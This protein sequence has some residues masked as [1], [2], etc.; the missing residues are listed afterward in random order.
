ML[1]RFGMAI[2]MTHHEARPES[3]GSFAPPTRRHLPGLH[4]AGMAE[5]FRES[6][7]DP[8][9]ESL[10]GSRDAILF[11]QR[12]AGNAAVTHLLSQVTVQPAGGGAAP[13][14]AKVPRWTTHQLDVIQYLLNGLGLYDL[15]AHGSG[16]G[17][18]TEAGLEEAFAGDD[19]RVM[20]PSVIIKA[21]KT[22]TRPAKKGEHKLG[23]GR[24]FKDGVLDMT[25]AVGFHEGGWSKTEYDTIV[26]ALL[27]DPLKFRIVSATDAGTILKPTGH[28][29][30]GGAFG[31]FFAH[32]PMEYT[33]P[34]GGKRQVQIILRLVS[35]QSGGDAGKAAAAFEEGM[36]QSDVAFYAGHARVGSGPDFDQSMTIELKDAKGVVTPFND[37]EDFE[38]AVKAMLPKKPSEA[39]VIAKIDA[40]VRTGRVKITPSSEGNILMNTY[41]QDPHH[42]EALAY[43]MYAS[44]A[45]SGTKPVT[46]P[47]G[48]LATEAKAHPEREYR[49]LVFDACRTNDYTTTIKKTYKP[50]STDVMGTHR[51]VYWADY[52]NTFIAFL[53]GILNTKSAE[54]IITD[55]DA[56]QKTTDT[57]PAF[58]KAAKPG[59]TH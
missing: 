54:Q 44:L 51:I 35:N 45:K 5:L 21:L 43:L 55:M 23:Y 1:G 24:M 26:K 38:N 52:A 10:S 49:V 16:F 18:F 12:T 9:R 7:K 34:V 37:Y 39:D 3:R 41:K 57:S 40:L 31:V 17:A 6:P 46:G 28:K 50:G 20:R 11:L 4:A 48:K 22:A 30:D 29:L 25:V 15:K 42:S 33:S 32:D 56:M 8:V 58:G 53:N 27:G 36:V 59:T 19:W 13:A 47:G 2:A 14:T